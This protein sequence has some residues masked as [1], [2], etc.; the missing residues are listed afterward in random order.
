M[1][2]QTDIA[3]DW[4]AAM[5][6]AERATL[7]ERVQSLWSGYG[8][9][10][11]VHLA[12]GPV[13]SVIVKHVRPPGPGHGHPRGW[14]GD[15][16]HARKLRS[17]EV[18][19]AWY[20]TWA[21]RCHAGCRVPRCV[22]VDQLADGLVLVLEDLDEAGFPGRRGGL[23]DAELDACLRW[24]AAFHARFMGDE[25]RG[26]WPVGTYWHLE[27]RPD[28]LAVMRPGALRDAAAAID[29]R[30][31]ACVHQT[32]VHGDAKVA[33][34]CFDRREARGPH[35]GARV[36]AVDFQYVGGGCGVKDVAY[37]LGSCLSERQ[38]ERRADAL[39]DAY[40]GH[41]RAALRRERPELDAEAIEREW[42][43]LCMFAWA[44][45]ER[46]LAGWSPGHAK[47]TG[48]SA[49]MTHAALHALAHEAP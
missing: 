23:D 31:N 17:Y 28:E 27:T 33:N 42:R 36:A 3:L 13:A 34:F 14:S 20:Q 38:L 46:F 26:L 47:Q 24:L 16:S 11:R 21:A 25:P 35:S 43:S 7:G 22:G 5:A 15:R 1:D 30:L 6:G 29:E 10:R 48:F 8:E 37:F 12:A 49:R 19:L 44:D 18:E 41:L 45:F 2:K 4:V 40:F 39:T 32:L 9:I